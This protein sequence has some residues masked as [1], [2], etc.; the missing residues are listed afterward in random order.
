VFDIGANIGNTSLLLASCVA[1]SGR[2]FAFE[3][4]PT[5]FS[6][7]EQ[8]I[9]I[10]YYRNLR[11]YPLALSDTCGVLTMFID[12]R[13]GSGASTIVADNA[14]RE[15]AWHK[16][17]YSPIS[18]TASTLDAFCKTSNF[19][20]T[21]L[22][23]DVEGAEEMVIRGGQVVIARHKPLIWFE[24]W[25]GLESGTQINQNLGHFKQLSDLGYNFFLATIFKFN[26]RWIPESD[27]VNPLQLLPLE[28]QML[29]SFPVM[30][31]D[32]LAATKDHMERLQNH[33]LISKLNAKNHI[34]G[35]VHGN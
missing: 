4:N 25:C 2:V 10:A 3:P 22:K 7:L 29:K 17:E 14:K 5:C 21:F 18:V 9:K 15:Q 1:K 16:A 32:I 27:S 12:L 24:C 20:P 6:K 31:C 34:L 28:P 19:V 35:L 23:V 13:D 33:D 11:A 8:I 26:N 30:G